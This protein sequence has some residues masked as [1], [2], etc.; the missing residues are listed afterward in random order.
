M[1][2]RLGPTVCR[3]LSDSGENQRGAPGE[4]DLAVSY[5]SA[6]RGTL[7]ASSLATTVCLSL[8][9]FVIIAMF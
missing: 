5:A 9:V 7:W 1:H 2:A 3:D 8:P 6:F 4:P